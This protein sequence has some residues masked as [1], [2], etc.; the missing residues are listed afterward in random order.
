MARTK[1]RAS[2]DGA[3]RAAERERVLDAAESIFAEGGFAAA[4]MQD[5]AA[6]ARTSLRS[7]YAVANG[8]GQIFRAVHGL[9]ARD[10]LPRIEA[11]LADEARNPA[12]SLMELIATVATFLM[13]HPNFLRIALRE[14][15]AWALDAADHPLVDERHASDR[16][17]ERLFLRGIRA[18]AFHDEDPKLMVASLR[19]LEQV[20][21]AAWLS[22]RNRIS[23]RAATEAIQRQ[24]E[25]LFCR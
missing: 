16:L 19:A 24:A 5:I 10:L 17:L 6:A 18:G 13:D 7:V 12:D 8:K 11:V 14:G 3:A 1:K 25:R 22:S 15:R 23:K 2:A 4:R 21:L 9:R 20:Q